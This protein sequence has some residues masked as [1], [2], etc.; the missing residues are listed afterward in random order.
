MRSRTSR[1]TRTPGNPVEEDAAGVPCENTVF[2]DGEHRVLRGDPGAAGPAADGADDASVR[3]AE[4]NQGE[5]EMSTRRIAVFAACAVVACT[6]IGG[7]KGAGVRYRDLV[8]PSITTIKDVPYGQ[9]T[10]VDGVSQTLLLDVHEPAGDTATSRPAVVWVHGGFFID[11]SKESYRTA[12]TQFTQAGY[13]T[14]SINY[15]LRPNLPRGAQEI[16]LNGAVQDA[17]D[18]TVDAQHD[19]QAAVRFVRAHAAEYRVDPNRI[20]IAGHSAG[21]ITAQRVL[22]NDH[23]PGTSGSPGPSSRVSA[24]VSMAGGSVPVLLAKVDPGEPPLQIVHGVADDVVPF[25]AG[26]PAVPRRSRCSASA[27]SSSTRTKTTTRSATSSRATS[28]TGGW[29]HRRRSS[30]CRRGWSCSEPKR[31]RE[32]V[33]PENLRHLFGL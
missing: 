23:D 29:S 27:S 13:V 32:P 17:I 31:Q 1:A 26:P 9:A 6:V 33:P 10:N 30:S 2:H 24:A 18:A 8:F 7:A 11:G 14:F 28:C 12:W 3:I 21:G 20:A 15:R 5:R 22:F 25:V 16:I 4:S 19:A